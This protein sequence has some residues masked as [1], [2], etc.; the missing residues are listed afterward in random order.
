MEKKIFGKIKLC[1]N[2]NFNIHLMFL[3]GLRKI[4][5][6]GLPLQNGINVIKVRETQRETQRETRIRDKYIHNYMYVCYMST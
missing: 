6:R 3:K 1:H 2:V 4:R 5:L